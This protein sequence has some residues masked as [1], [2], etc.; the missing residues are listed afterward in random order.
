MDEERQDEQTFDLSKLVTA[1]NIV[2]IRQEGNFLICTSDLGQ[3]FRQAIPAGKIINKDK[4][5]DWVLD[6]MYI[7]G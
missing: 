2:N 7:R 5:G 1:K 6:D 3:V 4:G